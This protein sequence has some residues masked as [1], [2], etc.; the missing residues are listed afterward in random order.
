VSKD[1]RIHGCFSKTKDFLEERRLGNTDVVCVSRARQR[2][3]PQHLEMKVLCAFETSGKPSQ[4]ARRHIPEDL[5]FCPNLWFLATYI[6]RIFY[7]IRP[8]IWSALR[9]ELGKGEENE[10]H[11]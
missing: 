7:G 6:S 10:V 9:H 3:G 4:V 2:L 5:K 8:E 11:K 1:L